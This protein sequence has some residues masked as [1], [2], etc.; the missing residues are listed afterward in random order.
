M[1]NWV[2]VKLP[3]LPPAVA[4]NL[5]APRERQLDTPP[6]P[7]RAPL[8][9]APLRRALARWATRRCSSNSRMARPRRD[10]GGVRGGWEVGGA[11]RDACPTPPGAQAVAA[12]AGVPLAQAQLTSA[13]AQLRH[14]FVV[15]DATLPDCPL[16]YASEGC[17]EGRAPLAPSR[18]P[19]A[20]P[21][22]AA[23]PPPA[24]LCT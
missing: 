21:P 19:A 7:P 22:P 4:P 13:L 12:G 11:R 23:P 10:R 17:G 9:Y 2:S 18:V 16:I 1:Q 14:T 15:A 5:L 24:A 3:A 6:P 20:N 8:G